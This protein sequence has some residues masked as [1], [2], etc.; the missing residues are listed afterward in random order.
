[1][2]MADSPSWAQST[3]CSTIE[4]L[5][6]SHFEDLWS[7]PVDCQSCVLCQTEK[8][9]FEAISEISGQPGVT[10]GYPTKPHVRDGGLILGETPYGSCQLNA[11]NAQNVSSDSYRSGI[12]PNGTEAGQ[13]TPTYSRFQSNGDYNRANPALYPSDEEVPANS[14]SANSVS[15]KSFS[16]L[17]IQSQPEK[18]PFYLPD[19]KVM[20]SNTCD[21]RNMG[22]WQASGMELDGEPRQ[23]AVT[24]FE[25]QTGYSIAIEQ[26][27]QPFGANR[28]LEEASNILVSVGGDADYI[29]SLVDDDQY[30]MES[31]KEVECDTMSGCDSPSSA[32]TK[33]CGQENS[34]PRDSLGE[35][36][37]ES[38]QERDT[39]DRFLIQHKQAG[40][41]YKQIRK[42][43]GFKVTESTLRG[44]YRNLTKK[45]EERVRK[46]VWK[47]KDVGFLLLNLIFR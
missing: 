46:P 45:K 31:G 22:T 38:S 24:A 30:R 14:K 1:M 23:S 39:Q 11:W 35:S 44:R 10:S 41:T 34:S 4:S 21:Y 40:K 19:G 7:D 17:S 18:H 29:E 8:C 25:A 2:K 47:K 33:S 3:P 32:T 12:C 43:G 15:L 37:G 20:F 28:S 13:I 27:L 6:G 9:S 26:P 42:E 36:F 5:S 16:E